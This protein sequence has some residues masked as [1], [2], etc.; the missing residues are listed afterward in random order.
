MRPP[1]LLQGGQVLPIT[2]KAIAKGQVIELE[3]AR[4]PQQQSMGLM[5]RSA[6]ARDRGMLFPFNPPQA[7]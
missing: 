6:L 5:F 3:V 1:N 2:A 4:T 7:P